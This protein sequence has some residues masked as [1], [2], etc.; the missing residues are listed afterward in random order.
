MTLVD[1]RLS[2]GKSTLILDTSWS[3]AP[4]NQHAGNVSHQPSSFR[5]TL[6]S[7]KAAVTFPLAQH[8]RRMACTKLYCFATEAH[9]GI[10][11]PSVVKW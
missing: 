6:L 1:V 4:G 9:V 3:K 8:R 5:L 11:L 2:K 7:S 10:N